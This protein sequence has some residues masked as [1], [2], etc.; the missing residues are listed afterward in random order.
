MDKI[1]PGSILTFPPGGPVA[2]ILVP[3]IRLFEKDYKGEDWHMAIA[4][5]EFPQVGWQIAH[6]TGKGVRFQYLR[7]YGKTF[8]VYNWLPEMDSHDVQLFVNKHLGERYD[9]G[10]YFGTALQYLILHYF[11]HSIP[12]W[13]DNQWTCWEFCFLFCREMGKP[14]Q[15]LH[16]YPF[17]TDFLE[18]VK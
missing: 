14:I 10:A 5:Q 11:N 16:K 18:A 13:L 6:A 7:D 1:R 17:I 3:L 2:G 9:I 8:N 4:V 15:S 12:R